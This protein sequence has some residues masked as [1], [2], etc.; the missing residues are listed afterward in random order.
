MELI[1]IKKM[2][3]KQIAVTNGLLLSALIFYFILVSYLHITFTGFFLV[4]G[5]IILIQAIAS[6]LKGDSTKSFIP[7]FEKVSNYEKEKMGIEWR[8]Q[9]K[10]SSIWNILLSGWMFLQSYW[11]RDSSDPILIDVT[12][13][14]L[15]I[16]FITAII[17]ISLITHIRKID[18]STSV[19][20]IKGYTWKSSLVAVVV[21]LGFGLVIFVLTILYVMSDLG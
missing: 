17:N 21:G 1:E 12:F 18:R 15:F 19:S 9:R 2:R 14:I 3:T 4:M 20:D 8:R 10:M 7:I 16:I 6:I 5:A 13:T 11:S